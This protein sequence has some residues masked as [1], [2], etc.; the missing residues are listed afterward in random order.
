MQ[1]LSEMEEMEDLTWLWSFYYLGVYTLEGI[2][3]IPG[4]ENIVHT[5]CMIVPRILN[6]EMSSAFSNHRGEGEALPENL[7][8]PTSVRR[9]LWPWTRGGMWGSEG[10][11]HWDGRNDRMEE[12]W[13]DVGSRMGEDG[14]DIPWET[15]YRTLSDSEASDDGNY[16]SED[17]WLP[18]FLW[19]DERQIAQGIYPNVMIYKLA[20]FVGVEVPYSRGHLVHSEGVQVAQMPILRKG[21]QIFMCAVSPSFDGENEG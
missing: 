8:S 6:E 12:V 11:H 10:E 14:G 15:D 13:N 2:T 21:G 3:G 1:V 18:D 20:R 9:T 7:L 4:Q 17:P 19:L 16:G 5:R